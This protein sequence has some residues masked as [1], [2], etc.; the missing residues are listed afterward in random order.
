MQ[1]SPCRVPVTLRDKVK[2]KLDD[3]DK[4]GIVE[5]VTTPTE[6]ISSMVVVTTPKKIR[7]CLDA[8]DLNKAAIRPKY[9]MPTLDELL[10]KFSKAKVF[11]TLDAKDGFYQVRLDESSSLKTTFWSPFER[12]KYLRLPFGINL[13]PE[14]FECKLHEKLHGLRGVEVIRDDILVMGSGENEDEAVKSMNS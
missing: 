3:L 13:A 2:T 7:I 1:H 9:Q 10:P 6:W 12:Y 4:K 11:S 5:K 14:E 8:R